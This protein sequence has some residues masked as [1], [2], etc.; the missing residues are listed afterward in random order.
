[1]ISFKN[2]AVRAAGAAATLLGAIVLASPAFATALGRLA[3]DTV[4]HRSDAETVSFE[5]GDRPEAGYEMCSDEPMDAAVVKLVGDLNA[6][7]LSLFGDLFHPLPLPHPCASLH[8]P[9]ETPKKPSPP[10]P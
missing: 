9:W 5:I 4:L 10:P 1:M 8:G 2:P 7:T 6:V 3:D